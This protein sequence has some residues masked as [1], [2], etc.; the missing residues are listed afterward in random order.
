MA[1]KIT[2]AEYEKKFGA[3]QQAHS[4]PIKISRSDYE[5]KFGSQQT[6]QNQQSTLSKVGGIAKE[7]GVG[8]I[9]GMKALGVDIGNVLTPWKKPT[10]KVTFAG[11]EFKTPSAKGTEAGL[12]LKQGKTEQ[13]LGKLGEAA[14]D[15]ASIAPVGKAVSSVSKASSILRASIEGAKAAA[16]ISA[17]YG[18]TSGMQEEKG[19]AGVLRQAA[20][21]GSIGTA[22]GGVLGGLGHIV[23]KS[24]EKVIPAIEK[25]IGKLSDKEKLKIHND[26]HSGK[27]PEQIIQEIVN[28]KTH[29]ISRSEY[30]KK[31]GKI[32]EPTIEKAAVEKN[33]RVYTG[34]D[35][36][37]AIKKA[38]KSGEG[39]S[40]SDR[41]KEGKFITSDNRIIDR[42]Q[43]KEEF[44]ITQSHEV[45]KLKEE[46]EMKVSHTVN[47]HIKTLEKSVNEKKG[48]YSVEEKKSLY[49]DIVK[50]KIIEAGKP[51]KGET[52]VF[53]SGEG[54]KGQYVSTQP[55]NI[56]G[57]TI[58]DS[59]KVKNV[60]KESLKSTGNTYDDSSGYRIIGDVIKKVKK[61]NV[62]II[63]GAEKP[64]GV[65]KRAE[66]LIPKE[67]LDEASKELATYTGKSRDEQVKKANSIL[68]SDKEKFSR[69][70]RGEES[71]PQG[72]DA[73]SFTKVAELY[74][75]EHGDVDTLMDL[76]KSPLA[77]EVSE[78]ASMLSQRVGVGESGIVKDLKDI[79]KAIKSRTTK[80]KTVRANQ[81][82]E[83]IKKEVKYKVNLKKAQDLL[84]KITC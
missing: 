20:I 28:N 73:G 77:T 58:D 75:K 78:S 74:A 30:E 59:F 29:Q 65:A 82:K 33:G 44:G 4:S 16:P 46:Q 52:M 84:D 40:M 24:I 50:P 34:S 22:F 6:Q 3:I 2:R 54:K 80:E 12:L 51:K 8:V 68:S 83:N 36:G 15:V 67:K 42:K 21:E 43:A 37:E 39:I 32:E 13:G 56:W 25:T 47:D 64:S 60:P 79:D 31:F 70:L 71:L 1:I 18:A 66:S 9:G 53:F 69:I 49:N 19:A 61:G 63:G 26:V 10:E 27:N 17:L 62:Q 55:E 76:M 48:I 35:H 11:R 23:S 14:L 38:Q 81:T 5:N 57:Y 7:V 41:Q 72:L 45:P